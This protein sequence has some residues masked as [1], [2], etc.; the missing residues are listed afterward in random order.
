MYLSLCLLVFVLTYLLNTT[1]ITVG[2]HRGVAHGA[3]QLHGPMKRLVT[4]YGNWLTGLDPKAWVVMHRRH[5]KYSDKPDDPHSPVN[6][7]LRGIMGEQLRNYER[8]INGLKRNDPSYTEFA[9][10]LDFDL[11]WLTRSGM[12]FAPYAVHAA[13]A[14]A[15]GFGF[16]AWLLGAAY[17]FGI[18]SHPIEGGM[19]NAFGHAIGG[20]NFDT[21]DNSRNNH[22][23]AWLVM[24]EGF[25]NNH[26]RYP[27]S[28]KFSY[29]KSEF[30]PGYL[31]CR[32]LQAVGALTIAR[33]Q[34]IPRPPASTNAR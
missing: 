14:L 32:S 33:E 34:L 20:R 30:D 25:Q 28:A 7:G 11:N 5:H 4:R 17:F 1:T 3:V 9:K 16:H 19:V 27:A 2:Y 15:L 10:D 8:T 18:M 29:R 22:P 12:W 31:V 23:I 6:V 13:A 26:H 21:D 24:G